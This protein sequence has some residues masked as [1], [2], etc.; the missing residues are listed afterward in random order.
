LA[1]DPHTWAVVPPTVICSFL[2]HFAYYL[3]VSKKVLPLFEL[4]ILYF[5]C[6]F[7]GFSLLFERVYKEKFK[8]YNKNWKN[9]SKTVRL[10]KGLLIFAVSLGS[11]IGIFAIANE[12]HKMRSSLI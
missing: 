8:L 7:F 3:M 1:F 5:G 12:F 6:M 10:V 11:F 9:E 4:H 2:I